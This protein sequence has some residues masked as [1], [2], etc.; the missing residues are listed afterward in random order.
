M[1]SH[2]NTTNTAS[3]RSPDH[4]DPDTATRVQALS[5][6]NGVLKRHHNQP[7]PP[8][9]LAAA[10][11]YRE[12]LKNH[13]VS[14]GGNALDGC[15][16]FMSSSTT[17]QA[18]SAS[19]CCA[20]CGCYRNFHRRDPEVLPGHHTAATTAAAPLSNQVVE[21]HSHHRHLPL[22]PPPPRSPDSTSPP[23][24]SLSYYSHPVH[25]RYP[26]NHH[27]VAPHVFLS[28]SAADNSPH[29]LHPSATLATL[30]SPISQKRFRT[31]FTQLQKER[32]F[33][34]AERVGWKMHKRDQEII[35][36]FCQEIGVERGVLKVWMH[37]N[38]NTLGKKSSSSSG[39]SGSGS[40]NG[41]N[42][43]STF[44]ASMNM[45]DKIPTRSL[46]L[47]MKDEPNG[48][49]HHHQELQ[50][51]LDVGTNGSSSS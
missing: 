51:H 42:I 26:H 3:T 29:P 23:A 7:P 49:D 24:I 45:P 48:G 27:S 41:V 6:N 19:F 36:E 47:Q 37:N 31:K 20:A 4:P 34:F 33:E 17:T 9:L 2:T 12:C 30:V 1:E 43:N 8:A 13:A 40:G 10:V 35:L 50:S 32:M 44:N 5:F 46:S 22:P 39:G 38:K 15:G 25:S 18:D 11:T 21:S 16:E 14:R 28:L